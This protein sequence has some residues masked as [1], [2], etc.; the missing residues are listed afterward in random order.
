MNSI[1]YIVPRHTSGIKDADTVVRILF[2]FLEVEHTSIV[3]VLPRE[4]SFREVGRMDIRQRVGVGVPS[5]KAKIETTDTGTV[6]VYNYN[7]FVMGPKL[8]II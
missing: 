1:A 4:Q 5:A 3:V 7:F 6:L 8:N 2:D